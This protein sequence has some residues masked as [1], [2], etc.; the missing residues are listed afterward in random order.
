MD[1][2]FDTAAGSLLRH[3]PAFPPV[4]ADHL[5]LPLVQAALD[6]SA[7]SRVLL[8][9]A[10]A[11]FGKSSALTEL[12]ARREA[13]GE[14]VAWLTL[15]D[16]D[17]APGVFC[18]RL[19]EA[20]APALPAQGAQALTYLREA[21][22]VPVIALMESLLI[23]LAAAER[24]LLLVLD[25]LQRISQPALFAGLNRLVQF[26]PPGLTLA[27][28][29]RTQPPLNLA[30]WRGKGLLLEVGVDEL[31]LSAEQTRQCLQAEGLELPD[32][33]LDAVHAQAEGWVMG[34]RLLARWLRE[35]PAEAER[36]QGEQAVEHY[37]LREVFE[38]LPEDIRQVLLSLAIAGRISG[39]L[40]GALTGRQDGQALLERL[41]CLGLFLVPLD[42]E[43]QWYR[44]HRLFAD[45]LAAHLR[46]ADPERF[47]QLHFN[48]SLWFTNHHMPTLAIEHARHAE[49]PEMLATLVDGYGLELINR[50]QLY[51][52][53]RWRR[54]V[55]D[56]I[57][58]RYPM[59][60]LSDVWS[61][62]TD[63]GLPEA[64]RLVDE[65]LGRWADGRSTAGQGNQYLS[66]LAVKAVLALQKDDLE[67]CIALARRV[68]SQLGQH[69][70]FLECA[71]LL[72]A[73]FAHVMQ[74][75]AEPARRLM[76]LAQQR[77]HFLDG[78]YLHMQLAT[79]EMVLALE[80]GQVE[81]ARLLVARLKQQVV[82]LFDQRSHALALPAI[83]ESLTAY[84]RLELDGLEERLRWALARVDVINPIDL[85]A[86]GMQCLARI[87]RL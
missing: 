53:A 33:L 22:E 68:E 3:A 14:H 71:I 51:L 15:S 73:S 79:I 82:P 83:A 77:A 19:V 72:V 44:F 48:A 36:L 75:H 38:G 7:H 5:Q 78:R 21:G 43:R 6:R 70:A 85:C 61:R 13:V 11:G 76:G 55:P 49:D 63:L 16:A 17:D 64:N 18:R 41:D 86:Q 24:P 62:A 46:A 35:H 57:A 30:T 27:L 60:V 2:L 52:I 23:D 42:R 84:Y 25:D 47:T 74:G 12:A 32:S 45:F 67:Q 39:E 34:V 87:Q 81:Q 31:R 26:A 1:V 40:A 37:L 58:A 59:L 80:Q 8:F 56:D 10:P 50:G 29:S 65:L 9:C 69:S 4:T 54:E 20:L 66:A 28:G